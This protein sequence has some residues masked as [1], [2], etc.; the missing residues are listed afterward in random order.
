[1]TTKDA[2]R[3]YFSDYFGISTE[4]IESFEALNISLIND[5]PLFIDP[6][7]LFNSLKSEYKKLHDRMIDYL[8]YLR[9]IS[10]SRPID[11]GGLSDWFR[12]SEIRQNWLGFSGRGNRELNTHE[13]HCIVF[14]I[15][16]NGFF[17][18]LRK[19]SPC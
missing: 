5:L 11:I 17:V 7:L 14:F 1:M 6:F 12:F 3:V 19:Q 16:F 8:A 15:F 18:F 2:V 4:E 13:I 9:D 10:M